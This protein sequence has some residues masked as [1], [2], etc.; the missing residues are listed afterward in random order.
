M[1]N[2]AFNMFVFDDENT[3]EKIV[4]ETINEHGE[5]DFNKIIPMPESLNL[6]SGTITDEAIFA[7]KFDNEEA[8]LK[9][10]H[11]DAQESP[12]FAE[13]QHL[14][15]TYLSNKEKYGATDWYD[16]RCDNWGTKWN[17]R[18]TYA[19]CEKIYFETAWCPPMGIIAAFLKAHLDMPFSFYYAEEQENAFAGGFRWNPETK[20]LHILDVT[21]N[22]AAYI[23]LYVQGCVDGDYRFVDGNV[24]SYYTY[25]NDFWDIETGRI[26]KEG[27]AKWE[28][29][30]VVIFDED[31][32]VHLANKVCTVI[33]E[34][35]EDI[36]VAFKNLCC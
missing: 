20:E 26:S 2:W 13:L 6:E 27:M 18:E 17:A 8:Y 15:H 28:T 30:P 31:P 7:T 19:E 24:K 1:P 33:C 4:S 12:T 23:Y 36:D 10:L 9:A 21:E 5:F 35:D 22:D 16:W 14:G 34:T 29:Y 32:F 3:F 11:K 25:E